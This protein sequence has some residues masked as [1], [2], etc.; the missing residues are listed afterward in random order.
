MSIHVSE[1]RLSGAHALAGVISALK[2]EFR[3]EDESES[4]STH[5]YFDS[6]DWRLYRAGVSIRKDDDGE[7]Q[8]LELCRLD[9]SRSPDT[10]ELDGAMPLFAWDFP[11]GSLRDQLSELL[12]M[13]VLLPQVEVNG[14]NRRFR[15][16][17]SEKKTTLRLVLEQYNTRSPEGVDGRPVDGRIRLIPVR[18]YEKA[19]HKVEAFLAGELELEP[20][21]MGALEEALASIG[22]VPGNYSSK[23]NFKFKPEMRSE[24]VARQ[25]H[26]HLLGIVESNISGT[27]EDLDSEYL[28]DLR[29]AIR[30]TRSALTQVK[31]VFPEDVVEGFKPRLAWVGQITGPTRDMHV[32]LLDFDKYR[33]SLPERFHADLDPLRRFLQVHQLEAHQDMARQME[34][35][36]FQQL[37]QDWRSYLESPESRSQA[38]AY[39]GRPISE[40]AGKRIYKIYNRVLE[41]GLAI[42]DDS[43]PE[44]LH[45][46]RKNCKKLRYLIEFFSSLYP[47]KDVK[48]LIRALK[49]LLDNLGS[50]QDLEV[51]ALKLREFAH[52][53]VAEGEVPAD[54]LLAMGMLVDGLLRRQVDAREVFAA[55]F[56]AFAQKENR[57]VFKRLFARQKAKRNP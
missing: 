8:R 5:V 12:E 9:E 35:E 41:E 29:V 46:L 48:A 31:G 42:N 16:V 45:E 27:V 18:G 51:Q 25:I 19:L 4:N 36:A 14:L 15:V 32:Y 37:R 3:L 10:L 2:S 28:H 40:L 52:Q 57:A 38:L 47:E 55:R 54:T 22:K 44:A 13:R 34:S 6:F 26:L 20:V 11:A 24:T 30:R 53:M 43:H 21:E 50:F 33:D 17:D 1:F 56:S 49:S 39:A 23:L 7:N